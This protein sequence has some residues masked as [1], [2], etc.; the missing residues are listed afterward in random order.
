MS[1]MHYIS[2][3]KELSLGVMGK[4]EPKQ[5][6]MSLEELKKT[7]ACMQIETLIKK[8]IL[9]PEKVKFAILFFFTYLSFS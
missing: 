6:G 5:I 8:G 9:I 4:K 2:A 7:K 3:N 1:F